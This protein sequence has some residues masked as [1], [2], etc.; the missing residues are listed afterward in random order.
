LI[1]VYTGNGKGKTTA[2]L[3]LMIRHL[4]A[5][6]KPCLIQFLKKDDYSE[7]RFLRGMLDI[8]QY[9]SGEWVDPKNVTDADR[10][11]ALDGIKKAAEILRGG[12][13]TLV[14]LDEINV[15]IAW[16]LIPVEEVLTLLDIPT[17]AERVLTGRYADPRIIERADLVTEMNEVKHYYR[18]GVDARVGIEC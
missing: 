11:A 14:V 13:Y 7:I 9:G 5:G 6:G 1:H 15:A 10:S 3:G 4:G 18:Q 2:A 16:N 17:M 12:E 8:F